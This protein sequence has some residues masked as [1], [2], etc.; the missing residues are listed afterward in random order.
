MG[1]QAEKFRGF[2]NDVD[3][4]IQ[5]GSSPQNGKISECWDRVF[6]DESTKYF[7]SVFSKRKL[8]QLNL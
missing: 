6:D 5:A 1:I 8:K 7:A 2:E 4:P 3:P